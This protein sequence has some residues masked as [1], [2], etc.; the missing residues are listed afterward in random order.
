MNYDQQRGL[1]R[2]EQVKPS[3]AKL[4]QVRQAL[5]PANVSPSLSDALESMSDAEL[6]QLQST[7]K[8]VRMSA[9]A[10]VQMNGQSDSYAKI[11]TRMYPRMAAEKRRLL[12]ALLE[13][14]EPLSVGL[15]RPSKQQSQE[16]VTA[17]VLD[18]YNAVLEAA[19]PSAP[20]PDIADQL[21]VAA[22]EYSKPS[23][24]SVSNQQSTSSPSQGSFI[25]RLTQSESGGNSKAEITIKD[26]R[27]FVGL[28]QY[29]AAR[30]AD[31]KA[32]SG[33]RFTQDEFQADEALQ[34]EVTKWH[35]ADIDKAIDALGDAAKGYDR[36]GLRSVAHLGGKGGMQ[37]YVRSGGKYNPSDELGTSL[38]NYYDKFSTN[39]GDL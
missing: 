23:Q 17:S 1:M 2:P 22:R 36:D 15:V 11:V 29:G 26:G 37:K 6:E 7:A 16:S 10:D 18:D 32:A 5:G 30:L 8:L 35:I 12:V 39:G 33:K 31:Y 19:A 14:L 28:L 21:I 27:K 9:S 4:E 25:D 3:E 38:Q 13:E 34:G 20:E 24:P